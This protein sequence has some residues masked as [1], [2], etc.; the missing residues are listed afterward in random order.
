MLN[1][2]Y[3]QNQPP[4]TTPPKS[5][6]HTHMNTVT[7]MHPF[8]T[9]PVSSYK[10]ILLIWGHRFPSSHISCWRCECSSFLCICAAPYNLL[11]H[12]PV[13]KHPTLHICTPQLWVCIVSACIDSSLV[14]CRHCTASNREDASCLGRGFDAS[15]A[16]SHCVKP[17]S[18]Y[19]CF[20]SKISPSSLQISMLLFYFFS[21]CLLSWVNTMI[22]LS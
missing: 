21:R 20:Q 16:A 6:N 18:E 10:H 12:T 15:R 22:L 1:N 13:R 17:H 7:G 11:D 19:R 9:G 14:A 3:I 8:L 2:T 5:S 4:T